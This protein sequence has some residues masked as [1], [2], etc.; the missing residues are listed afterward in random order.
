MSDT[1]LEPTLNKA[2]KKVLAL[3][4]A[5]GE[6]GLPRGTPGST[7]TVWQLGEALLEHDLKSLALTLGGLKHL[8]Y[9]G[10]TGDLG[11]TRP[12]G[13]WRMPKGDEAAA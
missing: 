2:D 13:W 12:A 6:F 7:I 9:I 8:G 3:I 5:G 11:L 1:T 10:S 4:P